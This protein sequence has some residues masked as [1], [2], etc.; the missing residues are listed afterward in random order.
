MRTCGVSS[1]IKTMSTKLCTA[2]P[3]TRMPSARNGR[4]MTA[5]SAPAYT[6]RNRMTSK[7]PIARLTAV[8][9]V[10]REAL[11]SQLL[12]RDLEQEPWVID[13][14]TAPEPSGFPGQAKQPL[15]AGTHHPARR[16]LDAAG[17]KIE[18]GTNAD[19]DRRPKVGAH[20]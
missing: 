11:Q 18:G 8:P 9:S 19:Q 13:Q 5:R 3:A 12:A 16:L 7:T 2:M 6:T 1:R 4:L 10:D 17:V 15:E 14:I 20:A